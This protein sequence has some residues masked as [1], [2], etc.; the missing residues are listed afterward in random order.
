M[1]APFVPNA[2]PGP[3]SPSPPEWVAAVVQARGHAT[4]YRHAG[5]GRVV[6][7]LTTRPGARFDRACLELARTTRVI[8]PTWPDGLTAEAAGPWVTDLLDSFGLETVR[9]F[10][11]PGTATT[12]E[13]LARAL[14]DRIEAVLVHAERP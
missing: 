1:S 13:A 2:S 11:D 5:R 12:A 7:A 9:L 8:A 10:A 3:V 6:L 14:P 4:P